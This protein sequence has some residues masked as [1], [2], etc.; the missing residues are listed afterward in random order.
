MNKILGIDHVALNV[1]NIDKSVEFYTKVLGLKITQREPS[2]PGVEYFLDAGPSLI[3]IIQAKDLN[4]SHPFSHEGLGA[5]HFSFRVHSND[6]ESMIQHLE[7]HDV[8]I[9]YAK[10]RPQSWSLYFYDIDGN[11]LE[12]TAWPVQDGMPQDKWV[13]EIYDSNTKAWRKYD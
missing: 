11:K 9:E 10:K 3:G 13:K 4:D 5:N 8:K 1:R 7:K 12:V 6:F 2:K